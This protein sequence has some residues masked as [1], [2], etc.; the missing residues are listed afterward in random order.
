M[1]DKNK[2]TPSA[3]ENTYSDMLIILGPFSNS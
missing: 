1:S 2:S 3:L